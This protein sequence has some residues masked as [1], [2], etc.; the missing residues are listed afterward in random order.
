[1]SEI[2]D[3]RAE[4]RRLRE[5]TQDTNKV[6]H[7]MRRSQRWHTIFQIVWWL[8]IVGITGALYLYWV[9]PYVAGVIGAY[10]NAKSFQVQVEDWF[11]QFGRNNPQ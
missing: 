2:D 1:M 9:Q 3:L 4:V 8:S 11:A 7:G 6:V 10:D 5:T